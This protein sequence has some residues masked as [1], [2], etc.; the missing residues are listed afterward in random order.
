M[1]AFS[2]EITQTSQT[3]AT[4]LSTSWLT[5]T[6]GCRSP[7]KWGGKYSKYGL[8]DVRTTS[9]LGPSWD[10]AIQIFCDARRWMVYSSSWLYWAHNLARHQTEEVCWTTIKCHFVSNYR[11]GD[12]GT[13]LVLLLGVIAL[14]SASAIYQ[15]YISP[16]LVIY[17]AYIR[18]ISVTYQFYISHISVH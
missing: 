12:D 14:A 2:P 13:L 3:L 11:P 1:S 5:S 7:K 16:I 9:V 15:L 6:S 4:S 18:Q 17:Q 10:I 8:A